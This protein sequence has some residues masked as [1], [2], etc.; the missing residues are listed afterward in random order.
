MHI[1][2]TV[3][4]IM[5][6]VMIVIIMLLFNC[7]IK[8]CRR[9]RSK[10]A[11]TLHSSR[12]EASAE[13]NSLPS[14]N[15]CSS[16]PAQQ[17]DSIT[18][19]LP[20]ANVVSENNSVGSSSPVSADLFISVPHNP[21][22][23]SV[24]HAETLQVD[25]L[26][27]TTRRRICRYSS[28]DWEI[29]RRHK[30]IQLGESSSSV[31]RASESISSHAVPKLSLSAASEKLPA[32]DKMVYVNG[33]LSRPFPIPD[34]CGGILESRPLLDNVVY[35]SHITMAI[36]AEAAPCRPASTAPP[37]RLRKAQKSRLNE[38]Y[39]R[40]SE[41]SEK[42]LDLRGQFLDPAMV[43]FYEFYHRMKKM[44]T[45]EGYKEEDRYIYVVTGYGKYSEN[46]IP[47]IKPAVQS[48]LDK[49]KVSNSVS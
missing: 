2:E 12:P 40:D 41:P 10:T 15:R 3:M 19:L 39:V 8:W 45:H 1:E 18:R 27:V 36:G 20:S 11:L 17:P 30:T 23:Q 25:R 9:T 28:S 48:F 4:V 22:Q 33:R 16:Q 29:P 32:S 13:T 5:M 7:L 35:R 42:K 24:T 38:H 44:Y 49:N 43:L 6:I 21:T 31:V 47:K 34:L 14:E 26:S 46:G 37:P